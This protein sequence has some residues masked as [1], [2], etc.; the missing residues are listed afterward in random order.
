MEN[1][2]L[3]IGFDLGSRYS[4]ICWYNEKEGTTENV[5]VIGSDGSTQ[6]PTALCKVSDETWLYGQ[7]AIDGAAQGRGP[8]LTG[9]VEQYEQ[10][11][12]IEVGGVRYEKKELIAIYLR[13]ALK[14]L[15]SYFEVYAIAYLTISLKEV[16]KKIM[17]DITASAPVFGVERECVRIQSHIASYEYFA[18]NQKKELW[19]HDVGMFEYDEDGLT[20]YHL[21]INK[22]RQPVVVNAQVYNLKM[23]MNGEML[24]TE[25]PVDLDRKFLQVLNEILSQKIISTVFLSGKGFRMSWLNMAK[26]KLCSGRKVFLEDNIY[27]SGACYSAY[28]DA[29]GASYR[30]FIPVNDDMV[31]VSMY[32]KGSRMKEI[33]RKELVVGGSSWYGIDHEERFILDGTDTVVFRVRDLVT[34]VEKMIPLTLEGLPDRPDKTMMIKLNVQFESANICSITMADEGFGGIF[35]SSRKVWKKRINVAEYECDK[36]FKEKGRLLFVRE[37]NDKVPYYFNFTD[38]KVY[39]LEELCYYV[40]NNIYAVTKE[41]FNEELLYWI[42]KSLMEPS[43]AK[44]F[45]NLQKTNASFKTMIQ[46]LMNYSDYYGNEACIQLNYVLDEIERQNPIEIRKIQADNLVRYC[47]YMDAISAYM[48]VIG[49]MEKPENGD[50]TNQFKGNVYHNLAAAYMRLMNFG[51]AAVSYKKAFDLNKNQESLKCYL[52]ALKMNGDESE[53]FD[54]A[55]E[56]HL[57]EGFIEDA[58]KTYD[59]VAASVSMGQRPDDEEALKVLKR[60]KSVYRS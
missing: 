5:C 22:K 43:L 7:A 30:H 32:I 33:I 2:K 1:K 19:H 34:N 38:T 29:S 21:F 12:E 17:A 41:T 3:I 59:Q 4:K 14:V 47:R 11:P 57:S 58:L 15:E 23:Y 16:G 48:T 13:E 25:N 37:L 60:L 39:S 31:P 49:Q 26:R 51:S 44:G 27:A 54:A 35:P 56:Y 8:L 9:F 28:F 52:W 18:M 42:E 53:F 55:S 24:E 46:Y 6:I 10:V 45:K 20:Y 36:N 40:Y 50:M